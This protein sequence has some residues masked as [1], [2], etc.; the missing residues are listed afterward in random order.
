LLAL[1]LHPAAVLE[2]SILQQAADLD[3]EFS[4]VVEVAP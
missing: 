4:E 1:Q 2:A 3:Y